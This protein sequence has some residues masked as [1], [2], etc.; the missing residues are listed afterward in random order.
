MRRVVITGMGMVSPLAHSLPLSW[1]ALISNTSGIR[2]YLND[3]ILK[4]KQSLS[5]A[6]VKD[7]DYKRWTVPVSLLVLSA[8]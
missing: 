4:N 3:P 8:C 2:G 6:I 5:L 1:Q 7:F